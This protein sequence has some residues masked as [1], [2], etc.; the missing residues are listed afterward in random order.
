M[1]EKKGNANE[2]GL[3]WNNV[4]FKN[5]QVLII[6]VKLCCWLIVFCTADDAGHVP[7]LTEEVDD[8]DVPGND[9]L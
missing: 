4:E 5:R 7:A 9:T 8:D 1:T 3:L 6:C 2:M